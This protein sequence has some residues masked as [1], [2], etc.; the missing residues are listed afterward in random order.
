M[1]GSTF[2]SN[3]VVPNVTEQPVSI[4]D[5]SYSSQIELK[6]LIENKEYKTVD[7]CVSEYRVEIPKYG[8]EVES[9][10]VNAVY[11]EFSN[12]DDNSYFNGK[13]HLDNF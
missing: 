2:A 5:F 10:K 13:D 1:A 11:F 7:G 6:G 9:F 8:T 3:I 4:Y 12:Y